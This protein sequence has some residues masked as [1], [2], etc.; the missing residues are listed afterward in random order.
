M[1]Y[2][3]AITPD[4]YLKIVALAKSHGK[5]PGDS[6]YEEFS[7]VMKKKGKKSF[8]GTELTKDEL[9]REYFS[10]GKKVLSID[11]DDNGKTSYR[12][13]VSNDGKLDK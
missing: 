8:A 4:E 6:M 3:W 5:V 1:N 7:E 13:N 2:L 9:L 10:K 12:T 11:I